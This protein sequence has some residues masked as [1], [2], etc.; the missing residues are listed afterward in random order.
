MFGHVAYG[1]SAFDQDI[2]AWDTSGVTPMYRMFY[3][4][5]AFDQDLG[6]DTSDVTTMY[7]FN[8]A[9][10]FDQDLGWCVDD[11]V[12]ERRSTP[13]RASR[14]RAASCGVPDCTASRAM[15][16]TGR[17]QVGRPSVALGRDGRR[18][19]VRPHLDVGDWRGDG[20]VVFVCC[21]KD[22]SSFNEDIGAWDTSGV[23]TMYYMFDGAS[24]F[25]QDIGAWDTSTASRTC[26]TCSTAPRPSTRTSAGGPVGT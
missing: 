1:A 13:P 16:N 6:W 11:D 18:G 23:T 15:W 26:T 21:S 24:A 4:A 12:S 2:G 3:Y 19:D 25:D 9:S 14:R 5:S 7:L 10:A 20:H 22:A 8:G 17:H